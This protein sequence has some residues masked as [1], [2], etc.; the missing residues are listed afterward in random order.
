MIHD[1]QFH[2]CKKKKGTAT[3]HFKAFNKKKTTPKYANVNQGPG[4]GQAHKSDGVKPVNESP[5]LPF[6]TI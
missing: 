2:Q 4:L 1:Q 6:L 3:S 5:T